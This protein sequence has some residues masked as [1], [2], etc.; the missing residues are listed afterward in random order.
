MNGHIAKPVDPKELAEVLTRWVKPTA[1]GKDKSH[2]APTPVVKVEHPSEVEA[3]EYAL[4]GVSIRS[5]LARMGGNCTLYRRLL[6]SFAAR[7]QETADKL[8]ELEQG[9]DSKLLYLEAH[10]LKGE[11]GNLG[12]DAIKSAADFLGRHIKSGETDRL[13]RLT[14]VLARQ[15][16]ST[17]VTLA[18]L[19][20]EPQEVKA[21]E[22]S[23]EV[24]ELDSEQLRALLEQLATQLRS[25]SLAARQL[26]TDLERLTR[27]SG[28]ADEVA[29]IVQA[30][31]QLRYDAALAALEPLLER[32]R[33]S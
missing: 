3:L 29:E 30:V 1:A 21:E 20:E 15:C 13:S 26:A 24:R 32:G 12:L 6:R 5:G 23:G 7:H 19:D 31:R 25:K 11:A 22:P 2:H 27:G 16:E 17:L 28:S 8:R 33:T 14:E 4:P 18:N 9:G 10:N